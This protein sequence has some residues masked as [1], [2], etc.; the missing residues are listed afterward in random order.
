MS[1]PTEH[2]LILGWWRHSHC[3]QRISSIISEQI[4]QR[5]LSSDQRCPWRL[6]WSSLID[7]WFV[8]PRWL[9]M[10]QTH[11]G[12]SSPCPHCPSPGSRRLLYWPGTAG[13]G[14]YC[15]NGSCC[16]SGS[17]LRVGSSVKTL[18]RSAWR[19][20]TAAAP[21]TQWMM[22][23]CLSVLT[24]TV[25]L[26]CLRPQQGA[27][28]VTDWPQISEGAVRQLDWRAVRHM[29]VC[30]WHLTEYLYSKSN[31]QIHDWADH[32]D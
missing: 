26:Q 12:D 24:T 30:F 5:N 4:C 18:M 22:K 2:R 7:L 11:P 10:W 28:R 20:L 3:P 27:A 32:C 6:H 23:S 1:Q 31:H 21:L 8:E 13:D 16:V 25:R 17:E 19:D 14:Q 29:S 15:S 9:V